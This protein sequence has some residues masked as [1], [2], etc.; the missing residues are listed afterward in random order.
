MNA[1]ANKENTIRKLQ[2]N[3]ITGVSVDT[4]IDRVILGQ[5]LRS[6]VTEEPHTTDWTQP[7]ATVSPIVKRNCCIISGLATP[8]A[9]HFPSHIQANSPS[10]KR[11]R[12]RQN[13][14]SIYPSHPWARTHQH[15]SR[16][17]N[18]PTTRIS[19]RGNV[20]RKRRTADLPASAPEWPASDRRQRVPAGLRRLLV[21]SPKGLCVR[22]RRPWPCRTAI[23]HPAG[24]GD[25]GPD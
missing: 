16:R 9:F 4:S 7:R 18:T 5:I 11:A 13:P 14:F 25:R 19:G 6:S 23:E 24:E 15:W 20:S 10:S 22:G 12:I 2:H 8:L 17:P 21:P 3:G 1:P